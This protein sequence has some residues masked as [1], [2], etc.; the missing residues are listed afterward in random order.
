ME[1]YLQNHLQ[2]RYYSDCTSSVYL[3][4][5]KDYVAREFLW[6]FV[7][8]GRVS[9]GEQLSTLVGNLVRGYSDSG[10]VYRVYSLL[11]TFLHPL[12][13]AAPSVFSAS[14][15]V[16]RRIWWLHEAGVGVELVS[17]AW[18]PGGAPGGELIVR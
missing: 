12:S 4:S 15:L 10:R 1:Q 16:P 2:L 14:S 13:S 7:S 8:Q 18:R 5:W 3:W 6:L 9:S 17:D 11:Q